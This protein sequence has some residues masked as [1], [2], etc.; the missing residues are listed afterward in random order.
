[1]G[2]HVRTASIHRALARVECQCLLSYLTL[3]GRRTLAL[4][5]SPHAQAGKHSLPPQFDGTKGVWPALQRPH[6]G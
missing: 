3:I 1:M 6:I 2:R 5:E 4:H